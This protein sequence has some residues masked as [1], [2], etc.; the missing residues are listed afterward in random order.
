MPKAEV[1]SNIRGGSRI[2]GRGLIQGTNLLC[3]DVLQHAKHA[4]TRG[5]PRKIFKKRC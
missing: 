3:G 2:F 5:P 4:E 1:M